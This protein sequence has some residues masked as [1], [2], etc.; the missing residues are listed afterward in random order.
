MNTLHFYFFSALML[1][2]FAV[3]SQDSTY[4]DTTFSGHI[5]S[6]DWID[7]GIVLGGNWG[8]SLY[9]ELGYS[10]NYVAEFGGFPLFSTTTNFGTEFSYYDDFILAPKIQASMNIALIRTGLSAL[11]YTN[12]KGDYSIKLRPEIGLG[13]YPLNITYAYNLNIYKQSLEPISTHMVSLQIYLR[14]KQNRIG[15]YDQ[16]GNKA[17]DSFYSE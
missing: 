4:S 5:T 8:K 6:S 1:F 9:G 14:V 7:H 12:F 17:P 2:G 3:R 16:N 11:C 13:L 10:R 15:E